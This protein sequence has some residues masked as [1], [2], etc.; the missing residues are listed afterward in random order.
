MRHQACFL[1]N[2]ERITDR[3]DEARSDEFPR[4]TRKGETENKPFF[5]TAAHPDDPRLSAVF[6]KPCHPC[7]THRTSPQ[8]EA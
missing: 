6:G 2:S 3:S 8:I 5:P 1:L 7:A 4:G